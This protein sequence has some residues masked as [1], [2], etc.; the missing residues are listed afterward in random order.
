MNCGSIHLKDRHSSPALYHFAKDTATA[1]N[2]TGAC[3]TTWPPVTV[4]SGQQ[5]QAGTGVTGTFTVIMR[6]DGSQ[7]A[8]F[9]GQT[10]Y[11][12][13]GDS[14]AG[15]TNGEGIGGVWHVV[16]ASGTGAAATTATTAKSSGGGY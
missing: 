10:L 5:P 14:K 2:C 16:K 15:D 1:S 13:S 11:T 3:A 6:A 12:Y 4:P 7:Q 8:V 9:D